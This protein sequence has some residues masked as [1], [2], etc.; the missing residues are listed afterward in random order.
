[1]SLE[2]EREPGRGRELIPCDALVIAAPARPI[3]NVE[4]AVFGGERVTFICETDL[5]ASRRH[6]R[7]GRDGGPCHHA[8][9]REGRCMKVS[10][11]VGDFPFEP[12]SLRYEAGGLVV[13]G[14]MGAWP[15][16]IRVEPAD[17]PVIVR[18]VPRPVLAALCATAGLLL[19]RWLLG[20]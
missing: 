3:R 19:A 12:R 14:A 6:R 2:V 13:E 5:A 10:S 9:D 8:R 16:T 1:M 18:L 20:R 15:A 4:G 17:L 11:P 7:P